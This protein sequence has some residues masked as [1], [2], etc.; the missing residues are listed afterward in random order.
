MWEVTTVAEVRHFIDSR[1]LSD[2]ERLRDALGLNFQASP[3]MHLN[4]PRYGDPSTCHPATATSATACDRSPLQDMEYLVLRE[5]P[6]IFAW[7]LEVMPTPLGLDC[8]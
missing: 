6:H 7:R 4:A 8:L 3:Q 5:F 2:G 1:R